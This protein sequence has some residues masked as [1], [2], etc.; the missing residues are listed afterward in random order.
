MN[1][2]N[3]YEMASILEYVDAAFVS[4]RDLDAELRKSAPA[5]ESDL[6]WRIRMVREKLMR[7]A[8]REVEVEAAQ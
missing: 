4:S 7:A 5:Y 8:I 6:T 3:K 1:T 2:I